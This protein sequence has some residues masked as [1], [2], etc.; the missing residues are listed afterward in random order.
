MDI[1]A[2]IFVMASHRCRFTGLKVM[3]NDEGRIM[4]QW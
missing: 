4:V 1:K 3:P 2:V